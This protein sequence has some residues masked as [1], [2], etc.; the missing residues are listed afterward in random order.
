MFL[1]FLSVCMYV[2]LCV[3]VGGDIPDRLLVD[4]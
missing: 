2:R 3:L 4:S 1:S